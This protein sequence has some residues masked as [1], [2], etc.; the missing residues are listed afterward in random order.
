MR[1]LLSAAAAHAAA[2]LESLP[3]RPVAASREAPAARAALRDALPDGPTDDRRVL[4]ELVEDAE[5]GV[6]AMGS[7]RFFG[8]VIGGTLPVALAAD[9]MASTWDQNAGLASPT[10]AA[11]AIEEVAGAWVIDL[12]GLPRDASSPPATACSPTPAGTWSATA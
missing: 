9:W 3:E 1:D 8:F 12:L 6:T 11:A 2:Y 5:P 10:P 4:D 7:P